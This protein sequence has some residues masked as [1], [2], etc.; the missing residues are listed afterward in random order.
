[1]KDEQLF[2]VKKESSFKCDVDTISIPLSIILGFVVGLLVP[3]SS[4]LSP[5]Y[6]PISSVIGWTYF[7]AWALSFYPQVYTNYSKGTTIG[8]A[9]D[10]LLY[11]VIGFSSLSIYSIAMYSIPS[12]REAYERD[13]NGHSP[14]VA[15][16]DVCYAL[17]ALCL[18]FVQI[19]QMIYYDGKKQIP[20]RFA[21]QLSTILVTI[22]FLYLIII[23]SLDGEWHNICSFMNWLYFLSFVKV[24]ITIMKYIPQ[25][26]LNY[27]RK[28]T[29]GWNITGN[30]MDLEGSILSILQLIL[31]CNDLNDWGGITGN[32]VKLALGSVSMLYDILFIVQRYVLYPPLDDTI[33]ASMSYEPLLYDSDKN[34]DIYSITY[35]PDEHA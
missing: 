14:T 1:M 19:S 25:A 4:D 23:V 10:K 24:G 34:S 6:R 17:H 11:D 30:F 18:T 28:T 35:N 27:N 31:D 21:I 29:V 12:V 8:Y 32:F 7:F 2:H 15:I 22:I 9:S 16:N 33:Q 26:L 13:H 5:N 3:A 20:S